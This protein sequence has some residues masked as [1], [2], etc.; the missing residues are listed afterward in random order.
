VITYLDRICLSVAG[1]RMQEALHIGPIAWGWVTGVFTMSYAAFEIPS[2]ALGDRFGPRRVLTRIVLWWS[3]FTSLTGIVSNYYLLLLTRL[4]FGVGEAGAFPNVGVAISRWFPLKKRASAWGIGMMASQIG[5]AV[6]P[7]LV[8]PIQMRY[9]WRA[10]FYMFGSLGVAWAIV[11]YWWFRDSPAEMSKVSQ[12]E[13]AEIGASVR[14]HRSL[15]WTVGIRS[16][17]L[18]GVMTMAASYGYTLYFFQ[19]WFP[20]Y[21]MKG[22]GFTETGLLLSSLP[23]FVGACA[24][25]FGGFAS[26]ALVRK[27][28][29]KW[30]RRSL[31]LA[32]LGSAA[33]FMT[34]VMMTE[35][36][37]WAL[38]FLALSYG[39][40]TIQQPGVMGVCLDIGGKYAGAVTGAMNT[41]TY[42]AAFLSSVVYGYIVKSYGY[43]APFIPMIVLLM[44]SMLLWLRIDPAQDVILE[45][46]PMGEMPST[47]LD[48]E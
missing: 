23:F 3:L 36:R 1:P 34:V 19:S 15:P 35:Q 9:G 4:C 33:L 30:G 20:T 5:G 28:G 17:N 39:G 31:G 10:S 44:I 41:A 38:I 29:L 26:D 21:L 6:A 32:G 8:V 7:L 46:E 47:L 45:A 13:V 25:G 12:Q 11:W 40:I 43:D 2:G 16:A 27:L 18:W 42:V 22:R 48:F 24:N 14:S 37:F